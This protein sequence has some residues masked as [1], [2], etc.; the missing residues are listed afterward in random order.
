VVPVPISTP[1]II[2]VRPPIRDPGHDTGTRPS[3]DGGK[4]PPKDTHKDGSRTPK[5][6]GRTPKDTRT[7]GKAS[8]KD[9]PIRTTTRTPVVKRTPT[10]KTFKRGTV[11]P[12]RNNISTQSR[13][14]QPRTVQ[15]RTVQPRVVQPRVVQPQFRQQTLRPAGGGSG[16]GFG[17]GFGRRR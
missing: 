13:V 6:G 11:K 15:P 7:G 16:R 2:D 9:A 17:G 14:V 8:G 1:P 10:A 5:D 12:T 4:Y 3:G